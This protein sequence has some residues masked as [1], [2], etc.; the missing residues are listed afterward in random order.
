MSEGQLIFVCCLWW[1]VAHRHDN[2]VDTCNSLDFM[3]PG[4]PFHSL[5]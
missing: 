2:K 3:H 5:D 4:G 1:N